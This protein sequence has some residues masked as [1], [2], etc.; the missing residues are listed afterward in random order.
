MV[1]ESRGAGGGGDR[2]GAGAVGGAQRLAPAEAGTAAA[3][4][5]SYG[6]TTGPDDRPVINRIAWETTAALVR[7]ERL[8]ATLDALI[9]GLKARGSL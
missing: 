5:A 8:E 4:S 3:L 7:L 6:D 2:G 1:G 9:A